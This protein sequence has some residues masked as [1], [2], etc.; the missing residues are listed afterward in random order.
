MKNKELY[1]MG[2]E[3]ISKGE[4]LCQMS[5]GG[6]DEDMES[7]EPDMEADS[8]MSGDKEAKKKMSIIMLKKKFAGG[9]KDDQMDY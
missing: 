6:D 1:A 5:E 8:E 3:L 9:S 2:K 4:M 7:E